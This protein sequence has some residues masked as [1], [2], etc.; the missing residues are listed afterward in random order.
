MLIKTLNSSAIR[1]EIV[2]FWAIRESQWTPRDSETDPYR[3]KRTLADATT[4]P[5][6]N[7]PS[8]EHDDVAN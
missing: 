5:D 6:A 3:T 7:N 1:E 4:K 2:R 8:H